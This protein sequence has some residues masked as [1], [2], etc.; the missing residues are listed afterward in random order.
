[1][2]RND[3]DNSLSIE[4]NQALTARTILARFMQSE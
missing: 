1:M 3:E 2:V 4:Q